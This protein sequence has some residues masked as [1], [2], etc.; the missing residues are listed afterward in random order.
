M[1]LVSHIAF[2][3][4]HKY[5]I[6]IP[7]WLPHSY[8]LFICH[9]MYISHYCFR[10][11]HTTASSLSHKTDYHYHPTIIPLLSHYYP[12]IIPLSINVLYFPGLLSHYYPI[13]HYG[14]CY[15]LLSHLVLE[16]IPILSH[17]MG[18]FSHIPW[19]SHHFPMRISS[20]KTFLISWG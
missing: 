9:Y 13:S 3:L 14:D 12:I 5:P 7:L 2:L 19:L 1:V 20:Q 8:P 16:I 11:L 4:Y 15:P 10:P 18:W 6:I 17:L